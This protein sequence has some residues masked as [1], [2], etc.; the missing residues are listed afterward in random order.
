[1]RE[2][3]LNVTVDL[4]RIEYCRFSKKD[5]NKCDSLQRGYNFYSSS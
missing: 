2:K 3:Q 4:Y 1:M 5:N